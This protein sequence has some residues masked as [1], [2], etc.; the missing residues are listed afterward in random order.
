MKK[1]NN[2]VSDVKTN[3]HPPN[4]VNDERT[5]EL[6]KRHMKHNAQTTKHKQ[7]KCNV[8]KQVTQVT[9]TNDTNETTNN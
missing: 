6:S 4:N 7:R 9:H 1:R 8:K 2:E 3:P 5:H